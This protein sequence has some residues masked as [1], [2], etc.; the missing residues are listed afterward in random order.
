MSRDI[1][2]RESDSNNAGRPVPVCPRCA[3]QKGIVDRI[4]D[5]TSPGLLLSGERSAS[6]LRRDPRRLEEALRLLPPVSGNPVLSRLAELAARLLNSPSSQISLLTDVQRVAAGDAPHPRAEVPLEDSLCTVTA[7]MPG[8]LVVSDARGDE[9][10]REL[11][12]VTSGQVGAY[13]G[14]PLTTAGGWAVGALCVFGPE[15]R[16]WSDA[17]IATLRQLAESAVTELE[18][19]ALVRQYESDRVRWGLAIDAAGIGTFDWDLVSGRLS[20]DDQL[21]RMFGY[22][23]DTFGQTIDAFNDRLHPDDAG[24]VNEALQ[25]CIDACGEYDAEYRVVR[26]DGETRWVHARGRALPGSDGAAVRVIGAAYDT[27]GEREG[28]ARV[29]RVLEAMPAGFYSLDRDWRFTHVN[30][31]GE[32]LL[33][34]TREDL[35]GKVLW[36]AFPAAVN[37]IFEE[38]Y[39]SAVRTGLP[40]SFDAYSPAPLDGWYELRA[41]PTPD[42]LSVYFLEVTERRQ[43]QQQAQRSAERLALQARVSAELA[44]TLDVEAATARLPRIVVPALADFCVLTVIDDDG[45][46]RDV[47]SWHVDPAQRSVLERYAEVRLDAMPMTAPVGRAL[48]SNEAVNFA[49]DDVLRLLPPGPARELLT[50]LA[51]K[52]EVALPLRA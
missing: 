26:P 30:A 11:P 46:P 14:M 22:D 48:H 52:T 18:L 40:V 20:W 5:R 34:R 13:L 36:E 16:E 15:P 10:V 44:G 23:I 3:G 47:G 50:S 4:A 21:T 25:Q 32:R 39:Y 35:I 7:A 1:T 2:V 29:T 19:S 42:G 28:A 37:S 12:P 51:P 27:T 17:D 24:R 31:Q 43:V 9:R 38:S 41:W 6:E 49:G 45:H 33:G 8:A